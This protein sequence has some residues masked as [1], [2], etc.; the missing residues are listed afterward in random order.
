MRSASEILFRVRQELANLILFAAPPRPRPALPSAVPLLADG[1]EVAERLRGTA[2]AREIEQLAGQILRHEFP[3]FGDVIAAGA[4]IEWRRDYLHSTTS[5]AAYFRRVPYLDFDRVG[6]HKGVWELNRHQHLVVLAQAFLLTRDHRYVKEIGDQ[7]DSWLLQNPWMR[8]I[9]W[10]SAL[11]VG[12]RALSWLWVDHLAGP[13]LPAGVRDRLMAG[14]YRHGRYL[15]RNLSVYFSPNTHLLGEAVA[16]HAL[17]V[18]Y[19]EWPEAGRWRRTGAALVERQLAGQVRPDGSHFEQSTYYHLY[20]LDF[21]LL[22]GILEREAGGD[23]PADYGRTVARMAEFL[24]AVT[25]PSGILPMLG[26]DDGGRLFHPYGPRRRFASATL[27]TA[28]QL[29]E[30]AAQPPDEPDLH[31]QG[32]WWTGARSAPRI[33]PPSGGRTSSS[34]HFPDAGLAVLVCDGLHIV[35]DAGPFGPGSAGHSHSDTL[36][37]VVRSGEREILADPG[38]YTYMEGPAWRARFRGSAGHNTIRIDGLDQ[39]RPA[40]PFRWSDPPAVV[41]LNLSLSEA[42]DLIEAEC[43]FSGFTHRRR[44][45]FQKPDRLLI[46]DE[47]NGPPGFHTVEQFWHP[48]GELARENGNTFCLAAAA[49][50]TLDPVVEVRCEDGWLAPVYGH[51]VPAAV[52]VGNYHGPLPVRLETR[53]CFFTDL[54]AS[55]E[56]NDK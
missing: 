21:F 14:L 53:L 4:E 37:L 9:N 1:R 44:V 43:R 51:R 12:F 50:L 36:S 39:A 7:L 41:L 47:L 10:A 55:S 5:G 28:E 42:E 49:E 54:P 17:G 48:G 22:H 29:T 56:I 40:G 52:V 45:L 32:L 46:I 16:L 27:A 30:R 34:R 24:R 3:V 8:G 6:D 19:P 33:L 35:F 25:G 11:E 2:F 20:A 15:E 38:T 13:A 18:T 23:L 26:D 31:E